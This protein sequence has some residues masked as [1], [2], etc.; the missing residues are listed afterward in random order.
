ME[1]PNYDFNEDENTN[2]KQLERYMPDKPFKML[3][4]GNSGCGKTNLLY[5][6]I[7]KPLL[8]YDQI[9]LYAKNLEQ[10]KHKHMIETMNDISRQ[11]GYD[12]MH[13]NNDEIKPVDCLDSDSQKIVIFDDFICDKNQKPLIDYFIRSRHKNCSV[14]YL[15]QSFYKTPKDIRLNCSHYIVYDFPSTNERNLISRELNTT[16]DQYE[17]ATRKPYSFLYVDKPK[18]MVKRN[19]Y[20]NI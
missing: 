20:G 12:I 18:K 4:G 6:M 1:I 5:H 8:Y 11:V 19:F 16:K 17:K 9:H 10:E 14:I 13:Y 2:F 7:M 3:I 15:S